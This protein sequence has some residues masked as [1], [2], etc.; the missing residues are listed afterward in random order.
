MD[1]LETK[2]SDEAK[3]LKAEFTFQYGQIRNWWRKY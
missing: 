2:I 1:R 3:K